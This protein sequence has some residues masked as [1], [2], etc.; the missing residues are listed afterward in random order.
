MTLACEPTPAGRSWTMGKAIRAT[1]FDAY[2]TL[3]DVQSVLDRVE[4]A[5][6]GRGALVTQIWRLKQLEYTWLRTAMDA[7]AD[8]AVVTRD[9][10]IYALEAAGI[11]ATDAIVADLAEAYLHLTPASDARACLQALA[12]QTTAIFSNGTGAMLDALV[13]NSGLGSLLT[14]V[15]SIDAARA[16][17]PSPRAYALVEA[18]TGV[19]PDETLF[20]SGNGFDVAGAK[21]F[22]FQVTWVRR[23]GGPAPAT[24][25]ADVGELFQALRL[26]AERL[27]RQPDRVVRS[28]LE[29]THDR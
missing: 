25:T 15:I 11:D 2:G 9:S 21:Q 27:D 5:C 8:F 22:G 7:F 17:K 26:R 6:P 23:G 18:R 3:Y 13:Q 28:L 16:F 14:H 4:R 10:L 1:V 20:V 24:A 19:P 12:G 29:I